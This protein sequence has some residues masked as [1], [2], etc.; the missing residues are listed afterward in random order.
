MESACH[1]DGDFDPG[2]EYVSMDAWDGY[3]VN[4]LWTF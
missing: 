1:R 2:E 4:E 3:G